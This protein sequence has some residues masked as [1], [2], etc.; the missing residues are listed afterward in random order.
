MNTTSE[1]Y[2]PISDSLAAGRSN[3][4]DT[5]RAS[6]ARRVAE[7]LHTAIDDTASKAE[8]IE[9]QLRQRAAKVGDKVGASQDAATRQVKDSLSTVESFAKERPMVA[10]GIAFAAGVLATTLLR[11]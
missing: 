3:G 6:T 8:G 5:P 2:E 4:T 11:R 9:E 7:A 1:T 10:A